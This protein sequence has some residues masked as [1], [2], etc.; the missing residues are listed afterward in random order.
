MSAFPY[1]EKKCISQ[2]VAKTEH[3]VFFGMLWHSLD[4]AVLHP[5]G[6]LGN[7]VVVNA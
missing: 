4:N 7:T 6:M 1:L 2:G 5:Y 3:K